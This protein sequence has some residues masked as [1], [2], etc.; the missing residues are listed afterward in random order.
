[1]VRL[2]ASACFLWCMPACDAAWGR[3][4]Y[5]AAAAQ[6]DD[7]AAEALRRMSE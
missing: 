5:T 1:M 4:R 7:I 2:C 6:G 3:C